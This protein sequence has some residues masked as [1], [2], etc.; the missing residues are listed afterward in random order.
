MRY[1]LVVLYIFYCGCVS[2]HNRP[3]E[4][5]LAGVYHRVKKGDSLSFIAHKYNA[6][7]Q[8][9]ME[10]NGL[11]SEHYLRTG[12]EIFIP[13]PDPIGIKITQY[14]KKQS[15]QNTVHANDK[16]LAQQGSRHK[17]TQQKIFQFPVPGGSIVH[18]FSSS[19]Q[20]P[21]DGLGISAPRGTPVVAALE[22][23][24]IFVG[25]ENTRYG[26]LVIIE[27]EQPFISVYAH[28]DKALVKSGQK[29]KQRQKIG[30]VG[31][32][33]GVAT[34]RLH[35][36]IRVSERPQDPKRFINPLSFK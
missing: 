32:S 12:Q 3:Y 13:S 20:K 1:F 30:S 24:V 29:I 5:E 31:V 23:K 25:N 14:N 16:S 28:L 6:N 10:V 7:P 11:E 2:I 18:Q 36:Q 21:Y 27:H 15:L 22:G 26:L 9:I 19:K 33:G 4:S 8:E 17:K 34:P 35:F